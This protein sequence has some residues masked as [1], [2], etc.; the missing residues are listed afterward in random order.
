MGELEPSAGLVLLEAAS[1]LSTVQ[2][3]ET[4]GMGTAPTPSS[5]L[6]A[7]F[8]APLTVPAAL[9]PPRVALGDM[10]DQAR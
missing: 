1:T 5:G 7:G 9:S 6:C 2:G 8:W 4:F 10:G 3:S